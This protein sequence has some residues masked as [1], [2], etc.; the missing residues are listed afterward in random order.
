MD[1]DENNRKQLIAAFSPEELSILY[2][3]KKLGY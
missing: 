2:K 1:V 3:L